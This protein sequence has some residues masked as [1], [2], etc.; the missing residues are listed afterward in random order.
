MRAVRLHAAG[1]LRIEDLPAPAAA[2][3]GDVLLKVLAAG[4][5]GSDIHNF[6]TGQWLTGTPRVGGHEFSAEVVDVGAGVDGFA[7]G[8]RVVADSRFWCGTCDACRGGRRN[9]CRHLGFVGEVCDGGF[10]PTTVL[11]ARLVLPVPRETDAVAA[12]MAEPLAVA[13]HAI[14]RMPVP[15]GEPVLVAGCGPI[16]G[17]VA[18]L[19]SR[20]HDGPV[21]ISDRNEARAALVAGETGATV[22]E[23]ADGAKRV[24]HAFD[25]T[26]SVAVVETLVRTLDGGGGLCLVGISHGTFP[27]DPNLLVE[28]EIALVGSHAFA[29]E[30]PEVVALLPALASSLRRFVDREIG[31]EDTPAAYDRIIA[32]AATGLKTIIRPS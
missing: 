7:P 25:A 5:C 31:I 13:L 29:D 15:A 21:L 28:R 19:L 26:G 32:G 8:D 20:L 14:R 10:A 3:P 22:L 12:A 4:I 1:D 16:G 17:L 18:L 27:L 2:G 11:P 9:L 24:R 23:L 30:L 6:R